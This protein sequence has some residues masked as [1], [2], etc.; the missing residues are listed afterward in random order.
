MKEFFLKSL[1]SNTNEIIKSFT[2]HLDTLARRVKNNAGNIASNREMS[3]KNE[4]RIKEHQ[5]DI[6]KLTARVSAF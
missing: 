6:D 4:A 3:N 2:S 5:V 1:K